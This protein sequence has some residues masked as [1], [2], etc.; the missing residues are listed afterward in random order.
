MLRERLQE[1]PEPQ[2]PTRW[3][4]ATHGQLGTRIVAQSELRC[5]YGLYNTRWI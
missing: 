3:L 5:A 4:L 2:C 1:E